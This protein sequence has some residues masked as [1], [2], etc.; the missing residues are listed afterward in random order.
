MLTDLECSASVCIMNSQPY[1]SAH[2]ELFVS[3]ALAGVVLLFDA[4]F[5]TCHHLQLINYTIQ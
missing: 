4:V 2:K 1:L 5:N 3:V